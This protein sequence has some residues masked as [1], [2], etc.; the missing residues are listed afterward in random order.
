VGDVEPATVVLFG[1]SWQGKKT[2][3]GPPTSHTVW[4]AHAGLT[5][6]FVAV[7]RK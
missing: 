7:S 3:R 1:D 4:S 6:D 5:D 2:N